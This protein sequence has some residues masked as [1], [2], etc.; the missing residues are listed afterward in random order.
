MS[1]RC[2]AAL[3]TSG[4][5]LASFEERA[6]APTPEEAATAS[7]NQA[8]DAEREAEARRNAY[9][10]AGG[11]EGGRCSRASS[12]ARTYEPMLRDDPHLKDA[13]HTARMDPPLQDDPYGNALVGALA[14][15]LAGGVG[16]AA[17]QA[18]APRAGTA[19]LLAYVA[20][21]TAR[22]VAEEMAKEAVSQTWQVGP[23]LG[24]AGASGTAP[25]SSAAPERAGPPAG[26]TGARGVSEAAPEANQSPAPVRIPFVVQG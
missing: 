7:V 8:H 25:G 15:G 10:A 12:D 2:S 24:E 13:R 17:R 21:A 14:G 26:R 22:E 5:R 19:H 23:E 9:Y 1:D 20:R 16:A 3:V 6:S 11:D 4:S 18:A